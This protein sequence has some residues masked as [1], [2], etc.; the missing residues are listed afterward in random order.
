MEELKKIWELQKSFNDRFFQ[1]ELGRNIDEL[2]F[3]E[4]QKWTKEF[5]LHIQCEIIEVLKEINWKMHRKNGKSVIES[6]IHEELIDVFKYLLGMMQ[7]WG[8]DSEKFFEEYFKKSYVVEQRY[9]QEHEFNLIGK[10][11]KVIAID[12][13]GVL[14][15][16]PYWFIKFVNDSL[17]EDFATLKELNETLGTEMYEDM[18]DKYRQSGIKSK[19]PTNDGASTVTNY[20]KVLGFK[21]VIITSRPYEKY[22]RIYPDTLEFLK[23]NNIYFDAILWDKE[24][25]LTIIKEFPNL[26]ALVEDNYDNARA[27]AK[28]GY[29]VLLMLNEEDKCSIK[30]DHNPNIIRINNLHEIIRNIMA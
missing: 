7:I 14:G 15:Q 13:D 18:K 4:Q 25:H 26:V 23:Y 21:I 6:N 11:E 8:M 2:T 28:E 16:Y 9:K 20:L 1:K 29:K 17:N 19:M 27:V 24:K 3:E 5:T 30:I 22:S 12:I 10:D